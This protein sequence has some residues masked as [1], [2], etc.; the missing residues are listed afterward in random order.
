MGYFKFVLELVPAKGLAQELYNYIV[1]Y[2]NTVFCAHPVV[3][4]V[5]LEWVETDA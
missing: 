1:R 5:G 3:V 4:R 2:I